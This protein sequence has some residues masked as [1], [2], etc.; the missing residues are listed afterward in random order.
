MKLVHLI[1][2][3][4]PSQLKIY[5][6]MDGVLVDFDKQ[7]THYNLDKYDKGNS[8]I[9]LIIR[10]IGPKFWSTMKWMPDGR[11]LWNALKPYKPTILSA[12]PIPKDAVATEGK[13]EW[14]KRELGGVPY[15]IEK[16]KEL[17]AKP[18]AIL[19]DDMVKNVDK[20]RQAG[21]IAILHKNTASTLRQLGDLLNK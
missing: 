11:T 7:I 4:N 17:Y 14:V 15:I 10:R 5:V 1:S 3:V 18:N 13:S 16:R 6:D 12:P 2:E 20:W 9:W 8:K 21:G 19:I